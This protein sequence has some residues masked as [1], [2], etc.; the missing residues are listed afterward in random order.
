MRLVI[1]LAVLG[2]CGA[3]IVAR[4]DVTA[5]DAGDTDAAGR[6]PDGGA[7][8][9]AGDA[10]PCTAGDMQATAPDGSCLMLVLA[11]VSFADAKVTCAGLG[12]HLAILNTAALDEA[13]EK[14]VDTV[15]TFIGLSDEAVE[16]SFVWVDGTPLQFSRWETGEPN[17]GDG[18]VAEDCAIIAG[19]RLIGGWDDRPC[20]PSNEA[21][22][23]LYASLCQR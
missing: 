5:E 17:D 3:R 19:A 7:I 6:R 15:D 13:G 16:G 18:R 12:A 9:A 4:G 2:G 11:P 8:D 21:A 23:G 10:A 1:A 20:A 22:G 14:L